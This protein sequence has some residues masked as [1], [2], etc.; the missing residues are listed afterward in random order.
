[1]DHYSKYQLGEIGGWVGVVVNVFL[2]LLK[3]FLGIV[4]KS[5]AL[6]ADAFHTLSDI[7][8]SVAVI[9]SFRI[10]RKPGDFE[11]PFG[12]GRIDYIITI[13]IAT[14]LAVTGIEIARSSIG[15]LL[16][17]RPIFIN[18]WIISAVAVTI[19]IKEALAQYAFYLGNKLNSQALKADAWHHR[20]DALSSIIV[21]AALIISRQGYVF[22]DGIAGISIGLFIIYIAFQV[23]KESVN[24]LLGTIVDPNLV[25]KLEEIALG[26]P[27]VLGIH[28]IIIHT[29]GNVNVI[30]Y[31]IEV[32]DKLSLTEAHR[33][34]ERVDARIRK[35]L[36]VHTAVH[37]DPVMA[38]T[39]EYKDIEEKVKQ[40]ILAHPQ[41][42]SFHDLRIIKEKEKIILFLDLVIQPGTRIED[43]K[44]LL[45]YV[46]REICRKIPEVED[47]K[48]K[49]E[50]RF[51]ISRRS[52]HD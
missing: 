42:H 27:D 12:H 30:S 36:N 49:M 21:L 20:T 29:Y 24:N 6:I 15:R 31:H 46:K 11:H 19:L 10:S 45:E 34:A 3:L 28:D 1:M 25:H 26:F 23:S 13:V 18:W 9:L 32:D 50:P 7:I 52:R 43:E 44:Q 4:S 35:V 22:V 5:V 37:V 39:P 40:Y 47:V 33:I 41:I 8:T 48:L 14:L 2:F 17:P 51:S 38:R 16:H